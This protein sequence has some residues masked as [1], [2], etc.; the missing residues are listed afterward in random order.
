MI[1]PGGNRTNC[2]TVIDRRQASRTRFLG[3]PYFDGK[4]RICELVNH[5]LEDIDLKGAW[6]GPVTL[7]FTAPSERSSWWPERLLNISRLR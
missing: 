4:P 7:E 5:H 3:I 2:H 6:F 1:N